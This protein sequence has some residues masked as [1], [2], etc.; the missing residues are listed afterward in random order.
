MSGLQWFMAGFG[1]ATLLLIILH[2]LLDWYIR[3]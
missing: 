3:R 1:A 2:E